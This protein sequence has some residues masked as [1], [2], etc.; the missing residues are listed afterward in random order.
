MSKLNDFLVQIP[1]KPDVLSTRVSNV[2]T[3][4]A[5]LKGLIEVGT[6]VMSGPTLASHPKSTD[7]GLAINGSAWLVRANT[8]EEVR[9]VVADDIYA[10]LGV[11]DI[12]NVT[13]TPFKCAVRKPL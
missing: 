8:E 4:M 12:D 2:G 6:I 13:V 3:H 9:A 1:D 7:E 10:K 5:R 11:W